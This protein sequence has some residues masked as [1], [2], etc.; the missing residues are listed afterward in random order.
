MTWTKS[1]ERRDLE[2]SRQSRIREGQA[3]KEALL[4]KRE[5]EKIQLKITQNLALLPKNRQ[6][7]L[8]REEEREKRM[9]LQETKKDMW[10][11]WRQ[12]K[13]RG[14][15]ETQG[16]QDP[17]ESQEEKLLKIEAEVKK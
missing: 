3:K 9:L 11:R 16:R 12:K 2:K 1:K 15:K 7:L 14:T 13:G 4:E 8:Q 6:I 5:K 10:R 17:R